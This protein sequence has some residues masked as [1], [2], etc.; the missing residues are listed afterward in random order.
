MQNLDNKRHHSKTGLSKEIQQVPLLETPHL[1][2]LQIN[3][4]NINNFMIIVL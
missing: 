3:G 2:Y 1:T 4:I